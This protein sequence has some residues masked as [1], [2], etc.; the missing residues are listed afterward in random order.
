MLNGTH[1]EKMEAVRRFIR[2]DVAL[3]K[4][5]VSPEEVSDIQ[6]HPEKFYALCRIYF[7]FA[8]L[9]YHDDNRDR[10]LRAA[11]VLGKAKIPCAIFHGEND[12]VC[13]MTDAITLHKA[14]KGSQLLVMQNLWHSLKNPGY[15]TAIFDY[16]N[17]LAQELKT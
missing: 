16:T 8:A 14:Y 9:Y 2:Y 12:Y 11:A 15:K 6:T 4:E 7:H 17:S 3:L 13:P 1:D 5:D 10:I